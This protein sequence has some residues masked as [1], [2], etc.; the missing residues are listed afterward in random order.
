M[1]MIA[2]KTTTKIDSLNCCS[3]VA[4]FFLIFLPRNITTNLKREKKNYTNQLT[5]KHANARTPNFSFSSAWI[6]VESRHTTYFGC[7]CLPNS[8]NNKYIKMCTICLLCA[9]SM[10]IILSL[11]VYM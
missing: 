6:S 11:C 10:C 8:K 4:L 5:T 3:T 7:L 1:S 2:F 9:Q